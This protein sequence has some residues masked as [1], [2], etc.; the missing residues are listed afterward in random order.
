LRVPAG[1]HETNSEGDALHL[2][3][4]VR[5]LPIKGPNLQTYEKTLSK[6]EAGRRAL[7]PE[8]SGTALVPEEHT[9]TEERRTEEG[10]RTCWSSDAEDTGNPRPGGVALVRQHQANTIH[11]H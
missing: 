5:L 8:D 4:S 2:Y 3:T 10:D 9:K 7:A 6:P 11:P 1:P